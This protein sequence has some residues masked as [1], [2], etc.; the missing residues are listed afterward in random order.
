MGTAI[1]ESISTEVQQYLQQ[2]NPPTPTTVPDVQPALAEPAAGSSVPAASSEA[3]PVF[4]RQG[5]HGR[6]WQESMLHASL[7]Y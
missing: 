5:W 4:W 2:H 7:P 1:S 3:E 6:R